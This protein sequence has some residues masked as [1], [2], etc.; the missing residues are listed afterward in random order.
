[1]FSRIAYEKILLQGYLQSLTVLL[2]LKLEVEFFVPGSA[3]A[4]ESHPF[5]AR[6]SMV[7][8]SGVIALYV[9]NAKLLEY[10]RRS[11]I[12]LLCISQR[13]VGPCLLLISFANWLFCLANVE[14]VTGPGQTAYRPVKDKHIG[15]VSVGLAQ[16][17]NPVVFLPYR[18]K[19]HCYFRRT[20]CISG[21]RVYWRSAGCPC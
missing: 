10:V 15:R 2:F 3:L 12:C 6:Q 11:D 7:E 21:S 9:R 18:L 20:P 19:V 17:L 13:I 16:K 4:K 8:C 14:N 1:M 5:V